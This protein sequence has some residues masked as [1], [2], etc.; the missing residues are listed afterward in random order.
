MNKPARDHR[1]TVVYLSHGGGPLP[2]LGDPSHAKMVSSLEELA[3]N[4]RR[5]EAIIVCSAHWERPVPTLLGRENPE[6]FYDYYGFPREAYALDYPLPGNPSLAHRIRELCAA[7]DISSAIDNERGF[8]H[9]VFIPLS[10][11]YPQAEIPTVQISLISGLDPL[12]HIRLG[13]ALQELTQENILIIGSGFSFHNLPQF[14]RNEGDVEDTKNDEFQE[15]LIEICTHEHTPEETKRRLIAWRDL[16][17][18][19]YCHP[20]E[21]HL[22]PLH[23]CYGIAE[24]PGRLLFDD[25]ILGKRSIALVWE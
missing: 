15:A 17:H 2:I 19:R 13:N 9:G 11:M 8:D 25:H 21:E 23:L 6:L 3:Q 16:P 18:A 24:R 20:R 7:S 1:A 5:P 14:F 10:I 12:A 4:V 22:L